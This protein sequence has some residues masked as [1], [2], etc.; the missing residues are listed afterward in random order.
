MMMIIII[1]ILDGPLAVPKERLEEQVIALPHGLEHGRAVGRQPGWGAAFVVLEDGDHGEEGGDD[2]QPDG[3][4]DERAD[5]LGLVGLTVGPD[6]VEV[7]FVF[8]G[9]GVFVGAVGEEFEIAGGGLGVGCVGAVEAGV[10]G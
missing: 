1:I 2:R 6:L 10:G 3:H 9:Q 8:G 7:A 5:E 4:E